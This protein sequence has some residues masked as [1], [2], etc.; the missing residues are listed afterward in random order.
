M[1][2]KLD[3]NLGRSAAETL[4]Q[5]GHDV[6]TVAGQQLS[7]TTDRALIERCQA[8]SRCLVTLDLEFSNPLVFEPSEYAGIVVLRL[9]N[10][11]TAEDLTVAV[12]TLVGGLSRGN[13]EGRLWVV[14]R[15]RL[16]EYQPQEG[17]PEN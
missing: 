4:R 14:Q 2:L 15:G 11:P 17:K 12:Q 8:E 7:G 9:P 10:R 3:E 1:R 16:R 5:A 13:A 6:A